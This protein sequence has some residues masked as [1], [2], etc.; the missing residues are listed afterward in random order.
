[1]GA[2]VAASGIPV[3]LYP[4]SAS[5]P[6]RKAQV[7]VFQEQGKREV[8]EG[9]RGQLTPQGTTGKLVIECG[10][11]CRESVFCPIE[12]HIGNGLQQDLILSCQ[13][14]FVADTCGIGYHHAGVFR[15][16]IAL[17]GFNG[18]GPAVAVDDGRHGIGGLQAVIGN[19]GL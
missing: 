5:G 14:V 4:A 10:F 11:R 1:M 9:Y 15:T 2:A 17:D 13:H 3:G 7:A 18:S 8:L 6:G 19:A 12:G 16:E